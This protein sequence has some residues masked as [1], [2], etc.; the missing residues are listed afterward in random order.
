MSV[1]GF[2]FLVFSFWFSVSV[3]SFQFFS[4]YTNQQPEPKTKNQNKRTK[5]LELKTQNLEQ[6]EFH[7]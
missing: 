4:S 6:T 5:N 2:E 1:L 7:R 3:L